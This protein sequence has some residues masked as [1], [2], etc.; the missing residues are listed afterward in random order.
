[1]LDESIQNGERNN[2]HVRVDDL[3]CLPLQELSERCVRQ[4]DRFL[5]EGESDTRFCFEIMRRAI[6]ERDERAWEVL[7]RNY[8]ALVRGWVLKNSAF[9]ATGVHVDEIVHLAFC[10]F[11]QSLTPTKFREFDS[12]ASLLQYLQMCTGSTI[13]ELLRQAHSRQQTLSLEHLVDVASDD[14]VESEVIERWQ[15]LGFWREIRRFLKD[16]QEEIIV[17]RYFVQGLKPRYIHAEHPEQFP[18]VDDVYRVKRN[19]I[20]RLRRAESLRRWLD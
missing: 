5:S 3:D 6:V 12:L 10:R 9:R 17:Y 18:E 14:Q 2:V 13:V 20:N 11:W 8:D 4:R 7:V 1:M 19:V 16:E 15:Q